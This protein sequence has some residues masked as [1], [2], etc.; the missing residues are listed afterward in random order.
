MHG[1]KEIQQDSLVEAFYQQLTN[2]SNE[3][4]RMAAAKAWSQWEARLATLLP[5][6]HLE[7][8]FI[9]PAIALSLARI[10]CHYFI[11]QCFIDEN[12]ILQNMGKIQE[13]PSIIVQGR[14][15]MICPLQ[16]AWEL[17]Q[18]WPMSELNIIRE[19]GHS[20]GEPGITSGLVRA[21]RTM[22]CRLG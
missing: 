9:D 12:Q 18:A 6:S 2:S 5:N 4:A 3:I 10:E 19:A 1:I 11:N 20:S 8:D 21:A 16:N 17:H 13:I 14:Y 22:A 7:D 15:D